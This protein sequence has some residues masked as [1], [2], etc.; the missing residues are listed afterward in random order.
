MFLSG[1]TPT[2]KERDFTFALLVNGPMKVSRQN[3]NLYFASMDV[4]P[5][6]TRRGGLKKP[7]R[8]RPLVDQMSQNL[9][10]IGRWLNPD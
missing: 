7:R 2:S 3:L 9:R 1:L 4:A 6:L 10:P 8:S 5:E